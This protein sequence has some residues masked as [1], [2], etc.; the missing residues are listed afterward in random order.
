MLTFN[1]I[2]L[3]ICSRPKISFVTKGLWFCCSWYC[4]KGSLS[5][6]GLIYIACTQASFSCLF[7]QERPWESGSREVVSVSGETHGAGCASYGYPASNAIPSILA[8][9]CDWPKVRMMGLVCCQ[10]CIGLFW[11]TRYF[12]LLINLSYSLNLVNKRWMQKGHSRKGGER[13]SL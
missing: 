13:T 2:A 5:L 7:K 10:T 3:I 1:S 11:P 9:I 4:C 12:P 8:G 6:F